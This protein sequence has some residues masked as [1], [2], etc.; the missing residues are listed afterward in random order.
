MILIQSIVSEF[1]WSV[2]KRRS[3]WVML[4]HAHIG[5]RGMNTATGLPQY[6]G[7]VAKNVR[8]FLVQNYMDKNRG[9]GWNHD[10]AT[11]TDHFGPDFYFYT[12][13]SPK[14]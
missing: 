3:V 7:L 13:P 2:L 9:W 6:L 14:P 10:W 1:L 12:A 5:Q 8:L 4:G 11:I